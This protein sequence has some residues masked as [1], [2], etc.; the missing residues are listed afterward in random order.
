MEYIL[1]SNNNKITNNCFRYDFK[2]P[3]RF[4]NQKISLMSMVF[5]N[6][7]EN[8]TDEFCVSKTCQ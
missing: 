2:I 3:I 1:N 8:I 6:Y 5:Y 7:F 4:N